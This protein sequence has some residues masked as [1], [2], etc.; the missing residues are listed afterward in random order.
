MREP[1]NATG[2]R[3]R[4][5]RADEQ[6]A[7]DPSPDG[8]DHAERADADDVH[9]P[10]DRLQRAG[11]REGQDAGEHEHVVGHVDPSGHGAPR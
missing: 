8:G 4:R 10:T 2:T 3:V 1:T 7:Q 5:H 6:V 9:P 11:H